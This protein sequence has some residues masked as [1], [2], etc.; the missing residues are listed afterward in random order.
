MNDLR[1]TLNYGVIILKD[2]S[3]VKNIY[4]NGDLF[5]LYNTYESYL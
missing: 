5:K 2:I 3:K 4:N 1:L